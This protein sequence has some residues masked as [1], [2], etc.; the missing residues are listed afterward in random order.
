MN[1]F[2][3]CIHFVVLMAFV[4]YLLAI[5][6]FGNVEGAWSKIALCPLKNKREKASELPR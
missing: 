5:A 1:S 4:F 2:S 3:L 6:N